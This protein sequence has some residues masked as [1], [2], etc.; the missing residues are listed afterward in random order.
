[1]TEPSVVVTEVTILQPY[2][3][4]FKPSPIV[5]RYH[6]S[7]NFISITQ[8]GQEISFNKEELEMVVKEGMKLLEQW[9]A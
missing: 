9:N 4:S 8:E 1:M 7:E 2:D 6:F 5:V 3:A